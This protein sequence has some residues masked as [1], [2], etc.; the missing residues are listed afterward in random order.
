LH[1]LHRWLLADG[2]VRTARLLG[3]LL[4]DPRGLHRH[5]LPDRAVV[6]LPPDEAVE[7]AEERLPAALADVLAGYLRPADGVRDGEGEWIADGTLCIVQVPA[8]R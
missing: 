8:V 5:R 4:R 7:V 2:R 1:Q 3:Q 6:A